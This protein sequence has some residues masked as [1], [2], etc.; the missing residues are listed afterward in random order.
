MATNIL[1]LRKATSPLGYAMAAETGVFVSDV[2]VGTG[3]DQLTPHG[4]GT[5]VG[6]TLTPAVP[7]LVFIALVSAPSGLYTRPVITEGTHTS[8]T[9]RVSCTAG[10]S[11]R[12]LAFA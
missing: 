9:I 10:W 5:M 1:T 4:L 8:V 3:S 6:T 7:T 2:I 11:Y 12:I